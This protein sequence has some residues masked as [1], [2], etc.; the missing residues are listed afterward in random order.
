MVEATALMS[1]ATAT[2]R[3]PR[4]LLTLRTKIL[5][6]FLGMAAISGGLGAYAVGSIGQAGKL[7]AEIFD[8]ALTSISY[9]RAASTDYA[10]LASALEREDNRESTQAAQH[11]AYLRE[12]LLSDLTIAVTR[13]QSQRARAAAGRVRAEVARCEDIRSH[14]APG[15]DFS[16]SLDQC[17]ADVAEQLDVLVNLVAGQGFHDRERALAEIDSG[18]DL[19]ILATFAAIVLSALITWLLSR[20]II[21][22][23]AAASTAAERIAS[24]ELDTPI[25]EGSAD[26]LGVLLGAMAVMRDKIRDRMAEEVSQRRSAQIRLV[27]AIESSTEA[28]VLVDAQGDIVIANS[29]TRNFLPDLADRLQPGLIFADVIQAALTDGLL[30][31]DNPEFAA[32]LTGQAGSGTIAEAYDG[33]CVSEARLHDGR[34]LRVSRST[35]REG[36]YVVISSDI[37]PLKLREQELQDS[38]LSLDAAL[39]NMVQGLCLFDATDRLR[40]V[41]RKFCEIH[42]LEAEQV[43]LGSEFHEVLAAIAA[44]GNHDEHNAE[45]IHQDM[46]RLI[47]GQRS[48]VR[49][50]EMSRGRVIAVAHTGLPQGGFVATYEDM[51]E[52]YRAESQ[53]RFMMRHDVL[54]GLPNRSQFIEVLEQKRS[55]ANHGERLGVVT[56]DLEQFKTIVDSMGHAIGDHLLQSVAARLRAVIR[57]D[58]TIARLEGGEFAVMLLGMSGPEAAAILTQRLLDALAEP[59]DIDGESLAIAASAGIVLSSGDESAAD[60]ILK[61]AG[62]ALARAQA[63]QRGTFRFFEAGMDEWMAARR[64]LALD[65]RRAIGE[66]Q[67]EVFY[68]PLVDLKADR[69]SGFEALLR[70]RHPERGMI[71]PAEFIP[72]AEE[73][74]LIIEIGEWVLHAACMEACHWPEHVKVAVNVS[75]VQFG[76]PNLVATVQDALA[77][78]G[79]APGRLEVEVTE[80]TLLADGERTLATLRALHENGVRIA[81]DDFGTGYSSLSYLRRFP[82]DKIKID[83]SFVRDLEKPDG[84]AIVRAIIGLGR[85][86]D[87]RITAEG[88]ETEAQSQILRDEG[89]N[90]LQGYLF[91]RPQPRNE[92]PDILQRLQH[93][94][95]SLRRIPV[96]A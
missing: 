94:A 62:V 88:V 11:V 4:H 63:E 41:N 67:F 30:A 79:L 80:S 34:W 75:P 92:L 72:V 37:T 51:T 70:W 91:S 20:R 64:T 46:R 36:G 56:L 19:N 44:Q 27:D 21:G 59:F 18:R 32:S 76:A 96:A 84:R 23:V 2:L 12:E 6:A 58:D 5:L 39:D 31:I 95:A 55:A 14:K 85:A 45:T 49:L 40:V 71:S 38:K 16:D 54:T 3:L 93:G 9:A 50:Q 10:L 28:V 13:S 22:P 60:I 7:T 83:Q 47:A 8:G 17:S 1:H 52:R 69:I 89:C 53:I 48:G 90:E 78:S 25:P 68:Q 33:A 87:M 26:E 42:G 61:N 82:F 43:R 77:R 73:L 65:L 35:T 86:L 81:L 24:G 29:Q 15:A 74:G 66:Q 57:E